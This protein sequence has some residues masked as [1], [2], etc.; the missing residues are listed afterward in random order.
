MFFSPKLT[1]FESIGA[2][3][4]QRR[5]ISLKV[6]D[7]FIADEYEQALNGNL[8]LIGEKAFNSLFLR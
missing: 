1:D 8:K 5:N 6:I 7:F 2:L 4:S 3:I